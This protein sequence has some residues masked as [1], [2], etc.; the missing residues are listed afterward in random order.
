PSTEL[1]KGADPHAA[2]RHELLNPLLHFARGLVRESD[3][4]DAARRHALVDQMGHAAGDHA[5]LAA[6]RSGQHQQGAIDV[7]NGFT[8]F[9]IQVVEE[10]HW[11]IVSGWC[12]LSLD[13]TFV[14][15]VL[16]ET[17]LN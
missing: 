2:P 16:V 15:A 1:V 13:V 7:A 8:L 4:K 14:G 6:A 12:A 11:A 9:R 10:I 17:P 3:G 5:R